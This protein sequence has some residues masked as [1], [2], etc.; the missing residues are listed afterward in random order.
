MAKVLHAI[1]KIERFRRSDESVDALIEVLTGEL[2]AG[3]HPPLPPVNP[4]LHHLQKPP[5]PPPHRVRATLRPKQYPE[6]PQGV[7]HTSCAE[8]A[9]RRY[10]FCGR[11]FPGRGLAAQRAGRTASSQRLIAPP[12]TSPLRLTSYSLSGSHC[13]R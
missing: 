2:A 1:A 5:A 4:P 12:P 9:L 6:L 11:N 7:Q 3:M 8:R 10:G 13:I